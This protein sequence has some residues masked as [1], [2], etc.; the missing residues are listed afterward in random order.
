MNNRQEF[1]A[2]L[3]ALMQKHQVEFNSRE[4]EF[5]HFNSL[6]EIDFL[7]DFSDAGSIEVTVLDAH[8]AE[9]LAKYIK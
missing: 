1:F 4:A 8:D 3:S 9:L 6:I 2:A 5:G 7:N